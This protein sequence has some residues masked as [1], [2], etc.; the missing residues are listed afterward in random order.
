MERESNLISKSLE[1]L[2]FR[3]RRSHRSLLCQE[4]QKQRKTDGGGERDGGRER[5]KKEEKGRGRESWK[6]FH[7]LG[8]WDKLHQRKDVSYTVLL[9]HA[10][11]QTQT[12]IHTKGFFSMQA[13]R[14][15]S[16]RRSYIT[17]HENDFQ[18]IV[19]C[20]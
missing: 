5:R 11:T 17:D 13:H 4:R 9:R 7:A 3:G 14:L 16:A 15:M 10:H 20:D 18:K 8:L 19:S 6:H 1:S 2:S 12:Q